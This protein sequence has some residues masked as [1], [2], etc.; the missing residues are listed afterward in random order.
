MN[1]PAGVRHGE[2][3]RHLAQQPALLLEV[4]MVGEAV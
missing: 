2:S 1:E 4:E 3:A